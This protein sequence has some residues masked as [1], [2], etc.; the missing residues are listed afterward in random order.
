MPKSKKK[1]SVRDILE[2]IQGNVSD[3]EDDV[4]DS[5][6]DTDDEYSPNNCEGD[7]DDS[8]D[9]DNP[10][11]PDPVE[12]LPSTS[13]TEPSGSGKKRTNYMWRKVNFIAPDVTFT[14]ENINPPATGDLSTPLEY[15]QRMIDREML[16]VLVQQ[17][18][19][20]SFQKNGTVVNTSVKE[21][22]MLMGMF[23]KMGIVS[24]P[25]N[26][27]YWETETRYPPVADTMSRNRFQLLL[28][29]L[30][31]VDNSN[32]PED[33][34]KRD[35]LWKIRP[36]LDMFRKN[37]L[38][39]IPEEQNSIDEMMVPF[40]GKFSSIKQYMRGKPHPWGFKIWARTGISG[41][42]CDFSVY[43]G[44]TGGRRANSELGVAGDVVLKLASTLPTNENYKIYAD[45][46]FSGIAVIL[47]LKA[48]GI[49]YVG[50]VRANRLP[51]CRLREEKDL[52]KDG[53]GAYDSRVEQTDNLVAVRWFDN[54]AVN[55]VSSFIGVEPIENVQ[56]WDKARKEHIEVARPAIVGSYNKFM[57][58]IDLLDALCA[59]YRYRMK[60][61]RWYIYL[62]WHMVTLA[63]IN[64]WLLYRRNFKALQLP[65]KQFLKR[66][67]FQAIVA[68]S[69]IMIN[70]I[71]SK[72]R[73]RPVSTDG[74]DCPAKP[75]KVSRGPPTDV[76]YDQTGHWPIKIEKRGRCANCTTGFTNISCEK[77]EV[78]LCF[79]DQNNCLKK[80]HNK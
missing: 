38:S 65:K 53:R 46:F 50:T 1:C 61:R 55:L 13:S 26:R 27:C 79:N 44:S 7:S 32:I 77:C 37:C 42:L 67:R 21:L 16:E 39:I 66:R 33:I 47:K 73:G 11:D 2:A 49:H 18:N 51:N 30:H 23:L 45:N 41:I 9:S 4:S 29:M 78:R 34:Q 31:F 71:P 24:M 69:L 64:A 20:Y 63:S 28:T 62:F 5:D 80:Y 25:G 22:E 70:T 36:W 40:H 8:D 48:M 59:G 52:K 17:T 60:S 72:K 14:G 74:V 68:S 43:Q 54:R 76:R 6:E 19:I 58:G 15:F 10:D 35:K 75:R 57:G 3:F 56:R 12:E